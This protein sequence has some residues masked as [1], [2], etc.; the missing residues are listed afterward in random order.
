MFD[1][2]EGGRLD[3]LDPPTSQEPPQSSS[4]MCSRWRAYSQTGSMSTAPLA[5]ANGSQPRASVCAQT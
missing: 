1:I 5:C 4:E 2:G 3:V